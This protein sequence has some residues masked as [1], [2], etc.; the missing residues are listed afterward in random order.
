ML[1]PSRVSLLMCALPGLLAASSMSRSAPSLHTLTGTSAA[2]PREDQVPTIV[3]GDSVVDAEGLPHGTVVKRFY[4]IRG[5]STSVIGI[6]SQT[7]KV[8]DIEG[9]RGLLSVQAF[10]ASSGTT[11]DSAF[12]DPRTLR[13]YW[14]H[15]HNPARV[16][17]L[18]F[19]GAHVAGHYVPARDSVRA[20]DQ[21]LDAAVFD[22]NVADLVIASLPLAPGYHARLPVYIYER[23]G[24]VW[25][26]VAVSGHEPVPMEHGGP[27]DAW[28]VSVRSANVQTTWWIDRRT[29]AV[30]QSQ[31]ALANGTVYRSVRI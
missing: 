31:F 3:A 13:P 17:T 28:K 19:D 21:T 22:S 12:G 29:H 25:Y 23:G 14:H 8:V 6:D 18:R 30:V 24:L 10:V 16:M 11:R 26:D 5:D 15:S 7:V 9:V 27:V 4:M 1:R 2:G 20:V